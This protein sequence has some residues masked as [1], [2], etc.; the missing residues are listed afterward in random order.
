MVG[1]SRI[2]EKCRKTKISRSFYIRFK[3]RNEWDSNK[4]VLKGIQRKDRKKMS[5]SENRFSIFRK[6][7]V[8]SICGTK[9]GWFC[10]I[11]EN[12]QR[13]IQSFGTCTQ[14]QNYLFNILHKLAND[15]LCSLL[16]ATSYRRLFDIVLKRGRKFWY[17]KRFEAIQDK[18]MVV[19]TQY[20]TNLGSYMNIYVYTV[21]GS[22]PLVRSRHNEKLETS[23][24]AL[25]C[26]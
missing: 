15:L 17:C 14:F 20:N 26:F 10:W 1:D 18:L 16:I 23:D 21:Q 19:I 12:I 7:Y 22:F 5:I 8:A 3:R 6:R 25:V 24:L 9:M 11:P 13:L 2:L 4:S